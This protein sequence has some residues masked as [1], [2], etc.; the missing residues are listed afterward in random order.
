MKRNHIW[1]DAK[2]NLLVELE[3]M[4]MDYD[5]NPAFNIRILNG[6]D[7]YVWNCAYAAISPI[8]FIESLGYIY[9]GDL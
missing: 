6:D 1:Y 8:E 2:K 3:S 9:I 5:Y 4:E 7:P